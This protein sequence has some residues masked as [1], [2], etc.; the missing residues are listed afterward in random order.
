MEQ[1]TKG[2]RVRVDIPATT[3]PDQ[4]RYHGVHGDVVDVLKDEV[5]EV[6][7]DDRDEA[8]FR[9]E[10]DNGETADFRWRDLRPPLE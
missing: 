5:S 1:F 8:I 6:T 3:D 9:V 10:L 7:G 4:D 2:D